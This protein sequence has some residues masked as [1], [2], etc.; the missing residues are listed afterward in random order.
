VF[1]TLQPGY[2]YGYTNFDIAIDNVRI[3]AVPEPSTYGM[4]LGGM[5]LVGWMARRKARS[6]A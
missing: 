5:G 4:L 3:T 2:V 6:V 1:T